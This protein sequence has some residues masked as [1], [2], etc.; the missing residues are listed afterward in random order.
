[1]IGVIIRPL[2]F[3]KPATFNYYGSIDNG[4]KLLSNAVRRTPFQT[5]LTESLVGKV[6]KSKVQIYRYRPLFHNSFVPVFYGRFK[7]ENGKSILKGEFLLHRSTRAFIF[8]WV[9]GI[10]IF[11]GCFIFETYI[12][13]K[14]VYEPL[15]FN[16]IPLGMVAFALFLLHIGWFIGKYDIPYIERKI[17]EIFLKGGI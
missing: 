15:P 2:F 1:M 17:Q 9:I 16:L 13:K 3:R 10:L 8:A 12:S 5:L 6:T 11:W 7:S 14:F 4:I